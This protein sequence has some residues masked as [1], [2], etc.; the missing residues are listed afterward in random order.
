MS[1][2]NKIIII[3]ASGFLGKYICEEFIKQGFDLYCVVHKSELKLLQPVNIIN[4]GI[5]ALTSNVIDSIYPLLVVHCARPSYPK[6]RKLGRIL[7]ANKAKNLN[8]NLL[9]QLQNSNSKPKLIFASGTLSYGNSDS[10]VY[11]N[12]PL[13]PLS[14]ARQYI[15]GE[16]P[17]V[18]CCSV[19]KYPIIILRFPWLLANGSWFK[20]FYLQNITNNSKIPMFGSGTNKMSILDINDAAQ[21]TV[22]YALQKNLIGIYNIFSKNIY[23]QTELVNHIKE[24]FNTKEVLYTTIY[25]NKFETEALEAFT[26]SI[27]PHSNFMDILNNHKFIS[28]RE[29][30]ENIRN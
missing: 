23:T 28:L 29:S 11:E 25:P 26:S 7:A 13:N 3:G 10:P 18:R 30:L 24:V 9:L 22:K 12:A 14:Y 20:W 19:N 8:K 16:L 2:N 1:K 27:N 4:G 17:I 5:K 21:L 6:L 15:K